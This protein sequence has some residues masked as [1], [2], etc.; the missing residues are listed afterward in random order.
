MNTSPYASDAKI[1]EAVTAIGATL[2]GQTEQTLLQQIF[3]AAATNPGGESD[4]ASF[5]TITGQPTDN[6]ALLEVIKKNVFV[7][8]FK[9]VTVLT[10]GA[11]AD[12]ASFTLPD[13]CTRWRLVPTS[14]GFME[15]NSAAGT[16]AG[17]SF[18]IRPS[19]NGAA[20]AASASFAGPASTSVV[21]SI[22]GTSTSLLPVSST[23]VYLR[24]TANS[25]NAGTVSVYLMLMPCL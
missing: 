1:T 23:T 25:A 9:N 12:V 19:A 13:W 20:N 22:V 24:Q 21:T 17:A 8:A 11:P 6:A 15:A 4:P 2:V 5:A 18:D 7:V 14:C 3:V 10:S 16:L